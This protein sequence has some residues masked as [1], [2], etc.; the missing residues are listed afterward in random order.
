MDA[1]TASATNKKE[2]R[3]R[4]R[5]IS[6]SKDNSTSGDGSPPAS[7]TTPQTPT[8]P[9]VEESKSTPLRFYQD[10]LDTEE[11]DKDKEIRSKS[12][13]EEVKD[14]IVSESPM[15]PCD[16]DDINIS[17]KLEINED[18]PPPP[19]IM[20]GGLRSVL[21]VHKRKGPKKTLTWR[22]VI[23]DVQYFELDETERVNVTKTF[24]AMKQMEHTHER[25]AFKKGRNIT[26]DDFMEE[27]TMWRKL[28]PIDGLKGAIVEPGVNS[29]E[30]EIQK[31]RQEK[32]MQAMYFNSK[33]PDSPAEADHEILPASEPVS[34]PL[35]DVTG[36]TESVNNFQNTP[37]PDPK[38]TPPTVKPNPG[39]PNPQ[40]FPNGPPFNPGFNGIPFGMPGPGYQQGMMPPMAGG[41]WAG[42]GPNMMMNEGMPNPDM[43]MGPGPGPGPGMGPGSMFSGQTNDYPMMDV[44]STA[45]TGFQ[46]GFNNQMG[47][48]G[49]PMGMNRPMGPFG[50]KNRGGVR[51]PAPRGGHMGWRS[52][53]PGNWNGPHRGGSGHR[54]NGRLCTHFQKKG[55][56]RHGD[57]CP[58]VHSGGV[59]P[60][61]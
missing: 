29:K 33:I 14:A 25:E 52:K 55:F 51:G 13:M 12:P 50:F 20:P 11:D 3:K 45:P 34:I 36:A 41:E 31:V 56:C 10:T 30:K 16:K 7:P 4:K 2:P 27:K 9:T 60:H 54:G 57:S 48:G 5:R 21:S 15:S 46:P 28:I 53:G 26:N 38:V 32:V 58:F 35:E 18:D 19:V 39:M 42:N 17:L 59:R 24:S 6:G 47:P 23:Q 22:T 8:S 37:W 61:F 1:L 43:F 44:G 40:M 49:P